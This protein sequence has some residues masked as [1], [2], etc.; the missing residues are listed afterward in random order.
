MEFTGLNGYVTFTLNFE[1]R[2]IY[3]IE[4]ENQN[5]FAYLIVLPPDIRYTSDTSCVERNY[6]EWELDSDFCITSF[7]GKKCSMMLFLSILLPSV[8]IW[9]KQNR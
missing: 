5:R 9:E 7:Q 8:K 2:W 6:E 1:C 4:D 3:L